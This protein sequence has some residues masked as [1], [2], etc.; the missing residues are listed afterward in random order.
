[1]FVW[2]EREG[3]EGG[4]E[5]EGG[6]GGAGELLVEEVLDGG[7]DVAQVGLEH[8]PQHGLQTTVNTRKINTLCFFERLSATLLKSGRFESSSPAGSRPY[9][10]L[11]HYFSVTYRA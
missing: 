5:G 11:L 4:G 8:L 6:R 10:C 7:H 2:E 3:G 9:S 1:M